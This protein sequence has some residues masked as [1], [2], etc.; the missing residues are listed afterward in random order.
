MHYGVENDKAQITCIFSHA[1]PRRR[2]HDME[3]VLV[4]KIVD[5]VT[6]IR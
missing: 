5:T 2:T 4:V 1:R 3:H 6:L